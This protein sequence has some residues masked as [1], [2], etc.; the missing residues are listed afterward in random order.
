MY[1]YEEAL[2]KRGYRRIAGTDEVGRGPLA[3]P[4]VCAAV[5]LDPQN[6]IEGLNDSKQLS[7]KKREQLYSLIVEQCISYN[8]QYIYPEE[9]DRINI[10]Q[11]SKKAMMNAI[12]CLDPQPSF[13]LSDAM[14][15]E[16]QDIPFESIIKGD[17]LSA[18]I[19]AAS[20]VAKVERDRYMVQM[21]AQYPGY[22]FDKH[23]GYPTKVHKEALE[24]LGVCD[25]HRLSYKPVRDC[26][27]TQMSLKL[28]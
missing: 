28:E 17:T 13:I 24:I 15:L 5:I 16:G 18:S 3:G 22:G 4:L 14:P 7:E 1:K 2:Q 8:V 9:I 6:P 12:A 21:S 25:I 27:E 26:V 11:A 20:I 19:A 23:K 10:Y